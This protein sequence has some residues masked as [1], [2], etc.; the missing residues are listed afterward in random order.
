[1]NSFLWQ[2]ATRPPGYNLALSAGRLQRKSAMS[3]SYKLLLSF[4]LSHQSPLIKEFVVALLSGEGSHKYLKFMLLLPYMYN[5]TVD[6]IN[7]ALPY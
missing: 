2:N 6:D 3:Y 7:P 4:D 1:M 5:P